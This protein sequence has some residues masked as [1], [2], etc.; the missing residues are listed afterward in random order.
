MKNEVI[1]IREWIERFNRGEY[2]DKN[3][4]TQIKAG[5]YDW[6]C[7][8]TSLANKTKKMGNIIKKITNPILLENC[9]V[10]FKN[11]CPVI[12][13]L[14]DSF[15]FCNL[16]TGDVEFC[17]N[18]DDKRENYKY[19]VYGR[20]NGFNEPIFCTN[21]SKELVN[22]FNNTELEITLEVINEDR[23]LSNEIN[24]CLDRLKDTLSDTINILKE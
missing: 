11:N 17:V 18:I 21:S 8:D 7:K 3:R 14:Y 10:F 2:E 23:D 5:W 12:G 1:S 13:P 6:F 15:K 16:I 22:F 20:Q 4:S 24:G 9:Y 19:C